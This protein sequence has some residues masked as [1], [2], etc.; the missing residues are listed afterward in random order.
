VQLG[1]FNPAV[2]A[3]HCW[4]AGASRWMDLI[5]DNA[6]ELSDAAAKT[7]IQSLGGGLE[8]LR[9]LRGVSYRM[10]DDPGSRL[11]VGVIAQEV[12]SVL[13]EAVSQSSR[14]AA[15]SYSSFVP[16]LIEAV[17]ELAAQVEALRAEVDAIK[18]QQPASAPAPASAP[19]PDRK[20]R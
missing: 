20:N 13:P 4:N 18:A 2:H 11:R 1:S 8:R 19:R 5:C 9:K 10:K 6:Y 3:V 16:V 15:V 7:D 14:G 17:K 12:A